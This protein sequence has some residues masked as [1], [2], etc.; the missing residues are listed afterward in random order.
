MGEGCVFCNEKNFRDKIIEKK[1]GWYVVAS[2]GQI[3]GGYMLLIPENHV[4]CIGEIGH[5][6]LRAMLDLEEGV[7]QALSLEYK[8]DPFTD[9]F[10]VTVF[11]HGIVGQSIKHAH[12]HMLPVVVDLSPKIRADFPN[13]EIQKIPSVFYLQGLYKKKSKPYLL[14]STPDGESMVC[15]NPPAPPQYLR[16]VIAEALGRP[17]RANWRNIEPESDKRLWQETVRRLKPYF[18]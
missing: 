11:E 2:L 14:W 9:T 4:S 12:L 18:S 5:N 13:S 8:L 16:T 17:E 1:N 7:C 10:S 3:I 6:K 15:W